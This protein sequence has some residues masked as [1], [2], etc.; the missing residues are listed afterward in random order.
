[1]SCHEFESCTSFLS[2]HY[3]TQKRVIENEK[4]IIFG[5]VFRHYIFF[6]LGGKNDEYFGTKLTFS[7]NYNE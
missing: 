1:M 2:I 4:D 5:K 3:L 6:V 7:F